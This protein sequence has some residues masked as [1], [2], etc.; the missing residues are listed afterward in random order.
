MP[1]RVDRHGHIP[2]RLTCPTICFLLTSYGSIVCVRQ[3]RIYADS[4]VGRYAK[5]GNT[6]R[7]WREASIP[8]RVITEAGSRHH[9]VPVRASTIKT[10]SASKVHFYIDTHQLTFTFHNTH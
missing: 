9:S 10:I 2:A 8:R 7:F 5:T 3:C 4:V 6:S 1:G